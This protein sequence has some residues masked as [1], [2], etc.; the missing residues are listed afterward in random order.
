MAEG[1][2]LDHSSRPRPD[3]INGRGQTDYQRVSDEEFHRT[4]IANQVPHIREQPVLLIA[5]LNVVK[6]WA[7]T[8]DEPIDQVNVR[9]TQGTC[10]LRLDGLARARSHTGVGPL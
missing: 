10:I 2:P 5:S 3:R 1:L 7:I 8:G 9:L 4:S 6:A